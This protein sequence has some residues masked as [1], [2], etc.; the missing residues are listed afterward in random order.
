MNIRILETAIWLAHD[1]NFRVTG[2]RLHLTQPAIS[3]R[4]NQLEQELGVKLFERHAREVVVTPEGQAFIDEAREIVRRYESMMNRHSRSAEF[5]SK[6]RIGLPSSMVHLLLP[7]LTDMLRVQYPGWKLEIVT[8]DTAHK[9]ATLLPERSIDIALTAHPLDIGANV[10]AL[11]VCTLT[12]VWVAS[13]TLLPASDEYFTPNEVGRFPIITYAAGTLN[14]DRVTAF[15]DAG[16]AKPSSFITSNSLATSIYMAISGLGVTIV[17]LAL[18][19]TQLDEGSLHVLHTQPSFPA[20]AYSAVWLADG[21]TAK[22]ARTLAG[23]IRSAAHTLSGEF[24]Q[25]VVFIPTA[26]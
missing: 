8:D 25:D 20:T 16:G 17:P 6:V 2:E 22:P 19:Q 24:S 14:A 1:R 4:I 3:S 21:E 23:L 5:T 18:I 12:M 26:E 11:P 7:R 13:P 10:E 9:L 15:F